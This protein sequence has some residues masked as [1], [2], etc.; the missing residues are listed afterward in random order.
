MTPAKP[1]KPT[2]TKVRG[3]PTLLNADVEREIVANRQLG[4][5]LKRSCELAGVVYDTFSGWMEHGKS[6]LGKSAAKR[7][8]HEQNQL[9]F[10]LRIKK[11]DSEWLRRCEIVNELALSPGQSQVKWH[12][13]SD[14]DR[15]LAAQTARWK[16]AHQAPDEY[17]AM[18]RSEVSGPDGGPVEITA[19]ELAALI[20]KATDA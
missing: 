3:R 2:T 1:T 18:V 4:L 12:E 5:S 6:A 7:T 13:A 9:D 14:D 19:T 8:R 17:S 16:L 20:A 10:Y 15:R 11:I